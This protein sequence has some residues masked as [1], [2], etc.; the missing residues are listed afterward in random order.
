MP[1]PRATVNKALKKMGREERLVR[2][3]GYYYISPPVMSS[4]LYVY[5]L[6]DTPDDHKIAREYIEE[7][8][9]IEDKKPFKLEPTK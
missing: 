5:S 2:G 8:L 9:S 3:D 6:E 4:G 1:T 7:C